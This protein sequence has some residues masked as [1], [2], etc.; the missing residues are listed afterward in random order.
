MPGKGHNG[1]EE[2]EEDDEEEEIS[3]NILLPPM[4]RYSK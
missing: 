2:D 4:P 1:L 3:F